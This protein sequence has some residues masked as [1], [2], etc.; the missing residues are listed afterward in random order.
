MIRWPKP[1]SEKKY[2]SDGNENRHAE[3]VKV[4]T[5]CGEHQ[6]SQQHQ[7]NHLQ[8]DRIVRFGRREHRVRSKPAVHALPRQD[9]KAET[10]HSQEAGKTMARINLHGIP[11]RVELPVPGSQDAHPQ[12]TQRVG[13]GNEPVCTESAQGTQ[14]AEELQLGRKPMCLAEKISDGKGKDFNLRRAAGVGKQKIQHEDHDDERRAEQGSQARPNPKLQ[15]QPGGVEMR[16][17]HGLLDP[18]EKAHIEKASANI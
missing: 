6:A 14:V 15:R 4:K 13:W 2:E 10:H 1:R 7:E 5:E 8:Q 12:K 16:F 17:D 9:V 18:Q 3:A 11:I